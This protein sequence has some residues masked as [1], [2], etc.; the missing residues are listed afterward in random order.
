MRVVNAK[1]TTQVDDLDVH[2]V[3]MVSRQH[4]NVI[5]QV[6]FSLSLVSHLFDVAM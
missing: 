2:E 5:G 3:L 4:L 6:I 1:A